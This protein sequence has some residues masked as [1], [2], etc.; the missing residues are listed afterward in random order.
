MEEISKE[1]SV[2]FDSISKLFALSITI[3]SES[4]E[5]N[6]LHIRFS[7]LLSSDLFKLGNLLAG[8]P[9]MEKMLHY[10]IKLKEALNKLN[11]SFS[12]AC[13]SKIIIT[14]RK[15]KF[16]LDCLIPAFS[17][18]A[19][20]LSCLDE[21][22]Q[23]KLS[24]KSITTTVI[25]KSPDKISQEQQ[26]L[27]KTFTAIKAVIY[28]I[29]K[30]KVSSSRN[31]MAGWLL[32][33]YSIFA[34]KKAKILA[35]LFDSE[36]DILLV[37]QFWNI[38]ESNLMKKIISINL[39]PINYTKMIFVPRLS[40]HVLS[41]FANTPPI[42]ANP[43]EENKT[44]QEP[45]ENI[46]L[47]SPDPL[48]NYVPIRILSNN[49]LVSIDPESSLRLKNPIQRY[50]K[51]IIHVHGGGYIAL[52]SFSH[53]TYTR[54]WA[55]VL[56]AVIFSIDYSLAPEHPFPEGLDDLWQAYTWLLNYSETL[57]GVSPGKI[58]L[59]GDSA[60][61][62][63]I[64]AL[65]IKA[66]SSGFRVPDGL[67]LIYPGFSRNPQ[68]FSKSSLVSL[69]D[70]LLSFSYAKASSTAYVQN[71][72]PTSHPLISPIFCS[73]EILKKFPKTEIM[74]T[75]NDPLSFDSYR[76][77]EKLLDCGVCVHITEFPGF[78][79]GALSFCNKNAIPSYYQF[80]DSSCELLKTLLGSN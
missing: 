28:K 33:Y 73:G 80:F 6:D 4:T 26:K 39:S 49:P 77:A 35:R 24:L 42:E 54:R 36:G 75:V 5:F 65:T 30:Y 19:N 22:H 41:D 7:A 70:K 40:P 2:C 68:Y 34:K 12:K 1:I 13:K 71:K 16:L 57:L 58:I 56:D 23:R 76:F 63:L 62:T 17:L 60:G 48:H 53:Q 78:I 25:A 9:V 50:E 43:I 52:S 72:H 18:D 3:G 27:F 51:L 45:I 66:I 44:K 38:N 46:Y 8:K 11:T 59:V 20:D 31:L 69:E 61:G 15:L 55:S 74:I 47:T 21:D 10:A 79:H 64:T 29:N 37:K 14:N 67:L 32:I